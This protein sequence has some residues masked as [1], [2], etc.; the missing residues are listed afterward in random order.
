MLYEE[1]KNTSW[2]YEMMPISMCLTSFKWHE[3]PCEYV[4]IQRKKQTFNE[5]LKKHFI[6]HSLMLI[7]DVW[8]FFALTVILLMDFGLK[9]DTLLFFSK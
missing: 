7:T 1:R 4:K 2:N 9:S 6:S 8:G 3:F 5:E